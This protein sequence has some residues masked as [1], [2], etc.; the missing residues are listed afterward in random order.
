MIDPKLID[1]LTEKLTAIIPSSAQALCNDLKKNVESILQASLGKMNL[2]TREEFD[3][4]VQV[5]ERTRAKLD[6]L[7]AELEKLEHK[8]S[9][10]P[11]HKKTDH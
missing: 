1:E 11:H 2:V 10:K 6:A 4:Q 5:L 8:Y 7:A 9:E 3:A